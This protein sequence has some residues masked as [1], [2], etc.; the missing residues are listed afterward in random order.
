MNLDGK[1][2]AA[3][4]I[5]D[6][7]ER[8]RYQA[9]LKSALKKAKEGERVK[10]IF[11]ANMSH[12]IRTPLNS[13]LGFTESLKE[14]F[15]TVMDSESEW[16]FDIINQSGQRLLHTIHEILDM[17]QLE[18]QSFV[19]N[20]KRIDL[21]DCVRQTVVELEPR[22]EEKGLSLKLQ[23]LSGTTTVTVDYYSFSQALSNIIE[24][25]IKYTNHGGVTIQL[26]KNDEYIV[27]SVT[28]TGIGMTPQYVK[29]LFNPFTQE[30]EGHTKK[31]Q[32]IGLGMSLAKKY[33]ELNRIR[34]ELNTK[35]N[36]GTRVRLFI[37][38]YLEKPLVSA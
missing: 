21:E 24:N 17:S 2:H 12:E 5:R 14:K 36:Q 25:A 29:R 9:K 1:W 18:T 31:F 8:K 13:I 16:M 3:A 27:L 15:K 32:G 20:P 11:L 38:Y 23:G 7:T 30:S 6:I 4:I 33:L 34:L 22:A 10:T 26:T 28:D 19:I 37:P 35:K